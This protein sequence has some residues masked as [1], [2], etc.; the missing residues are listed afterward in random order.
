MR[1]GSR[2]S[3]TPWVATP[4]I[5]PHQTAVVLLGAAL[6]IVGALLGV[7]LIDLT[8]KIS[9]ALLATP[10]GSV[11]L[12]T[13]GLLAVL[14]GEKLVEGLL[15]ITGQLLQVGSDARCEIARQHLSALPPEFAGDREH[16]L[17]EELAASSADWRAKNGAVALLEYGGTRLQAIIMLACGLII[18]P[19]ECLI[20]AAAYLVQ[21]RATLRM[22]ERTG[23]SLGGHR[24]RGRKDAAY[25]RSVGAGIS[26]RSDLRIFGY[27][28][29]AIT[30]SEA[31]GKRAEREEKVQ[32][33][34]AR[35]SRSAT[36][37]LGAIAIAGAVASFALRIG[38]GSAQLDQLPPLLLVLSRLALFGPVGETQLMARA[39]VRRHRLLRAARGVLSVHRSARPTGTS[40]YEIPAPLESSGLAADIV[41]RDL[42]YR[43]RS[44][45]F[46]LRASGRIPAGSTTVIVGK[47]GSG[48]STFLELLS[49]Q[50][51]ARAGGFFVAGE[52]ATPAQLRSACVYVQ[53]RPPD[54]PLFVAESVDIRRGAQGAV[55]SHWC[56]DGARLILGEELQARGEAEAQRCSGGQRQRIALARAVQLSS[57]RGVILL[58]EPTAALDV[59]A[60]SELVARLRQAAPEA[61]IV[62]VTHRMA[63]ARQADHVLGFAD[64]KL[65]EAGPP[66]ELAPS[67][68]FHR[69]MARHEESLERRS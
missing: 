1:L 34:R 5:A 54:Y 49:G 3:G 65:V 50:R 64:G 6:L 24:S 28:T 20:V 37:F 8:A 7:C 15:G 63:V 69:L 52:E 61:T 33:R 47:N 45:G 56:T 62:C 68:L 21:S 25:L 12:L 53:Q 26:G 38:S 39:F 2:G 67:G 11:G 19:I 22:L 23:E 32:S 29:W 42:A 57:A 14:L 18:A 40:A 43:Y 58:D 9:R 66:R 27:S 55:D 41:F 16:A 48:K 10:A 35:V 59:A 44:G 4:R 60:E 51:I 31:L 30:E 46:E 36:S 13:A 17:G